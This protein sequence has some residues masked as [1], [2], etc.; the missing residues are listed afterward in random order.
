MEIAGAEIHP[1]SIEVY[2]YDSNK[3]YPGYGWSYAAPFPGIKV[4][5]DDGSNQV[6]DCSDGGYEDIETLEG[7]GILTYIRMETVGHYVNYYYTYTEN[8]V[9]TPEAMLYSH[10]DD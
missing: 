6:Y 7:A 9:T 3:V 10:Y 2:S 5:Y 1:V 4:F 8:G